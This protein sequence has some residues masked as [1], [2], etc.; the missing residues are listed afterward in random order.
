MSAAPRDYI[1]EF[2]TFL[3]KTPGILELHFV[4]YPNICVFFLKPVSEL[5]NG[6]L[7]ETF[8]FQV[9]T[10]SAVRFSTPPRR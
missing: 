3:A 9:V 6:T 7:R 1:T 8:D 4:F 2:V 5:T 10:S